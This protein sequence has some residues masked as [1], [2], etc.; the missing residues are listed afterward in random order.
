MGVGEGLSIKKQRPYKQNG[1][2]RGTRESNL[3]VLGEKL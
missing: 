3:V 2:S 1:V